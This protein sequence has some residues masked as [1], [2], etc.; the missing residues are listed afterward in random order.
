MLMRHHGIKHGRTMNPTY[1]WSALHAFKK[2][3][4]DYLRVWYLQSHAPTTV[5][6][7]QPTIITEFIIIVIITPTPSPQGYPQNDFLLLEVIAFFNS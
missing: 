1:M 5:L 4:K 2:K 3:T 6:A 7:M